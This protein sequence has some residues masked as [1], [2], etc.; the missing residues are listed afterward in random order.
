VR[1]DGSPGVPPLAQEIG[2]AYQERTPGWFAIL[3]KGMSSKARLEALADDSIDIALASH[4]V[5]STELAG[6]GMTVHHIADVPVG[7]AV[8]SS[9]T[10]SDL[11]EAQVC[12][13]Y[14]GRVRNW[15][16]VGGPDLPIVA[17]TRPKGEV[18]GDVM[19]AGVPC[20]GA[21]TMAPTVI[22]KEL[23]ADMSN[24]VASTP[25]AIGMMSATMVA[26]ASDLVKPLSL[27]GVAPTPD[28]LAAGR[29]RLL[30]HTYFVTKASPPPRVQAF[31][32]FI[33]SE[34]GTGILRSQQ[35]VPRG[36]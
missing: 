34:P 7:F 19:L 21:L 28:N 25:G 14:R 32:D 3:G 35:A 8:N 26:V 23:P 18:D 31:L 1:I 16:E 9:V 29:Y 2:L 33:R 13:I 36:H 11:T 4:G 20:L 10:V 15:R 22:S 12:D 17:V 30:R 6:R 24:F 27:G 5:D